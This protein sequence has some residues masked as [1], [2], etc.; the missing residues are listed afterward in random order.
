MVRSKQKIKKYIT[1][2]F[3]LHDF[4]GRSW[5]RFYPWLEIVLF[6][7]PILVF[8]PCH[9]RKYSQSGKP[10]YIRRYYTQP[11]HHAPR[12]CRIDCFSHCM[13]WYK[14]VIQRSLVVYREISHSSLCNFLLLHTPRS[15]CIYP[16]N[17]SDSWVFHSVP[18]E[19]VTKQ[20]YHSHCATLTRLT[21]PLI[22]FEF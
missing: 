1:F 14:T 2:L 22:K 8:I 21:T 15:S 6:E 3:P 11:F 4:I 19:S 20:V 12:E 13:A 16:E 5:G 9:R 18:L 7:E 17:T 10:L